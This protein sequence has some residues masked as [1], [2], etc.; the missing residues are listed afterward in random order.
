MMNTTSDSAENCASTNDVEQ[1]TPF[2]QVFVMISKQDHIKLRSDCSYWKALHHRAVLRMRRMEIQHHSALQECRAREAQLLLELENERAKNRDLRQRL[3]GRKSEKHSK[4]EQSQTGQTKSSKSRGQQPGSVGHGRSKQGELEVREETI[5]LDSPNCPCCGLKFADFPGVE[6]SDV[7]EIEVKAYRRVIQR[8]RYRKTCQ[9]DSVPGIITAPAPARLIARGKYGISIW[10][11]LLLSKFLYCQ[12]TNRLLQD[13]SDLGLHL[14]PGTIAGGMQALSPLFVPLEQALLTKLRSETH[15]H[16]DETRWMVF[17]QVE[18][19]VGHRWYLW[20]FHSAS[21]IHYVLDP[22]RAATVPDE[23]LSAAI[24]GIINCDRYSA[25][26]K[27]VR[28]HPNFI[29]A[30]CW[31]H[32]RRDFLELANAHPELSTWAMAWVDKIGQLYHANNLRLATQENGVEGQAILTTDAFNQ[33]DQLVRQVVAEMTLQ[34]RSE[35]ANPALAEEALKVLESMENHWL[36][37]T[38]FVD[39]PEVPMDNNCVERILRTSVVGRKNFYGSYSEWS[40]HFAALMFSLLQT[41]RLWRV[42]PRTW[43]NAY[44]HACAANNNHPPTD[45]SPFLPWCMDAQQLALMR[46]VVTPAY[47]SANACNDTS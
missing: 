35:M 19:K 38:V 7:L 46:S 39:H 45:L 22:S 23:E 27:F 24:G 21:V 42:N 6:E 25:Y 44:L 16:A 9:C 15:W 28:L 11:T 26:K 8:K 32:E 18:G 2:A 10:V 43:L 17:V 29:L 36:G 40:G 14:T 37:L 30:Y 12:P 34:R 13:M 47:S 33:H 5:D 31:A 4:T 1:T 20:V 41:M 3:Y